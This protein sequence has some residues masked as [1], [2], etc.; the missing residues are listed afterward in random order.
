[1]R[2]KFIFGSIFMSFLISSALYA[3]SN[4]ATLKLKATKQIKINNINLKLRPNLIKPTK[5]IY[6][7]GTVFKNRVVIKFK[8]GASIRS[9]KKKQVILNTLN[10]SVLDKRLLKINKL[11][12]ASV[13]LDLKK[14]NVILKRRNVKSFRPLFSR[15]IASLKSDRLKA[16]K[17][18]KVLHADLSNYYSLRLKKNEDGAKIANELN[19]LSSVEI[20]YLAPIGKDA[21]IPP[22]TPNYEASQG[23]LNPAPQGIDAKYAWTHSGG[24][25]AGV[26]IIDIEQGWKLNH[27]DLRTQFYKNGSLSSNIRNINHGTAV[28]GQMVAKRD[29]SGVTGISYSARHGVVSASRK[30]R[31]LFITWNE[32]NVAEAINVASSK[33]KAG[34]VILIEQHAKGP[35]S[36][37]SC[38]CNCSQF[39]YIAMEYWQAEFDAIKAATAKG[40]VVV[41]AAGNGGMN[42]NA[43][44]YG[45][46]FKKSYRDS[47]AIIVGG[48]TS[49]NRAPKCWTNYGSRL[50]VQ[51]W[52][53]NVRTLGYGDIKVNGSD[54]RQWY[55]TSFSGT[56]SASPI[57]AGAV[58]NIQGIR[59]YRGMQPMKPRAI[60]KLL[61]QNGTPQASSSKK[62]GPLP[63]LRKVISKMRL[64]DCINFNYRRVRVV[65]RN[66]RWKVVDRN[67]SLL[68][69]KNDRAAANKARRVIR[70]YRMNRFCFVGR[71]NPY[72]TYLLVGSQAPR[73]RFNG[74]DCIGFNRG[75]LRVVKKQN[76]WKIVDGSVWLLDFKNFKNR[77][78]AGLRIIRRYGFNKICYVK[79]PNASMQYFRQ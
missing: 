15:N 51:G 9:V 20:A 75:N 43:S 13:R 28:L 62:I 73:G 66:N 70:H 69:F 39:E 8:E 38:G 40:I 56:S 14:I 44:R 18:F 55:A 41:E 68:D 76:R 58:V 67:S 50:D 30:R 59:K 54:Q 47:G 53:E 48:G 60:R 78:V 57:V 3:D 27:E 2:I 63:D 35:S 12:N 16:N 32:Y 26:K 52:G 17:K 22:T 77:A 46:R 7:Q 37:L 34:D 24:S 61:A 31:F 33:L 4:F 25:G 19:K 45:N 11:S 79:R 6:R 71:P 42:L 64:E 5:V 49:T 29:G 36:G 10:V 65:R 74:E 72:M 21:D 1:M 23:Y